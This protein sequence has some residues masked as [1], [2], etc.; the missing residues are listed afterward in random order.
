MP[1]ACCGAPAK[2]LT[3][4]ATYRQP[5]HHGQRGAGR[6]Q[7]YRLRVF[8]QGAVRSPERA[9][10]VTRKI[11]RRKRCLNIANDQYGKVPCR[12]GEHMA[13]TTKQTDK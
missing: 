10:I 8:R 2:I 3:N 11:A 6:H 13:G 7:T 9:V 1:M 12:E 4:N 5:K